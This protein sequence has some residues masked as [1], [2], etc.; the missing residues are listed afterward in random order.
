MPLSAS[1]SRAS[2][3]GTVKDFVSRHRWNVSCLSFTAD[4]KFP[5]PRR[6]RRSRT[7]R[8]S[9][10]PRSVSADGRSG[11]A[12]AAHRSAAARSARSTFFTSE[13][14]L[15]QD[16]A[17]TRGA[18]RQSQSAADLLDGS[19]TLLRAQKFPFAASF[20]IW[21]SRAWSATNF[22]SRAFSFSSE[23]SCV[24]ISGAIPPYF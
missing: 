4:R 7:G 19:P 20:K 8:R 10:S 23:R 13:T 14:D 11:H 24:A 9:V 16:R 2:F 22:F 21:L 6:G 3:L 1:C 5:C 15:Q 17:H 18:Q 12:L